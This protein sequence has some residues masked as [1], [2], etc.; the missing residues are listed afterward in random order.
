AALKHGRAAI[1]TDNPR[2]VGMMRMT[3]SVLIRRGLFAES[4]KLLDEAHA[5]LAR[6]DGIDA[7]HPLQQD[8]VR[9]YVN[10]YRA[11]NR[12]QLMQKWLAMKTPEAGE[13]SPA[14]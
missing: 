6:A 7:S 10:L 5:I 13:D 12:P 9:E 11:M 2:I 8:V 4:E 3:A 1:G 14:P